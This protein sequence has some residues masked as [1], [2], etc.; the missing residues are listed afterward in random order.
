MAQSGPGK[1]HREGISIIELAEMFPDEATATAWFESLLWPN[2]RHCPRCG[3]T[4]TS[5]ASDTSGLPYWCPACR[6][7]FSVRI[8]TTLERS[9]VPL[10]KW[11]WAVYLYV[12]NLKG[13]SS[14]KLH[15][16]LKVTQKTAWFMLHRLRDAWD[17]SGLEAF[18]GP[19]EADE[20]YIGGKRKNM[21]KAKRKA[22]K[23]RGAVG[24]TAVVGTKDRASNKIVARPI[25]ATDTP[26]VAGFVAEK[27]KPGAK[28]YT[29]DA[30][31]YNALD[32]W[33]DH[34]AVNHSVGEY[35]RGQAH[36]NGIESFWSMLK[37]GYQGTYHHMSAKHLGRYVTEFAGRHNV[38]EAD[39][40][41]QM[42]NVVAAMA[43]K[44]LMYRD[45]IAD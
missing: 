23:G 34:E 1:A 36:T 5:E 20:T 6:R 17:E 43:G 21:P 40:A 33:F 4:E 11:A 2:G 26:H 41:D 13:V 44:R 19:V 42:V 18:V 25:P 10:R 9:R 37:R 8:G 15:R 12:T 32:P 27:T 29:D 31:A 22:M 38:R 28:V 45:L 35:V 24:K 39:T 30:A 7:A 14:M 16:D 3:S